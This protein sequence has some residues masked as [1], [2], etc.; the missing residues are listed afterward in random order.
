[1]LNSGTFIQN[2]Y[3]I[4]SKIGSG[5]MADVY[6]AKDH[7]LNRLV[8]IKVLKPEFRDD[9]VFIS[10]FRTEAQSAAGLSHGN[11]VNIYDV[12]EEAGINYIVME[13]VE[14]IT[15]KEYIKDQGRLSVKE[16][17]SIAL[18]IS[19]GLEAAHNNGVIHRDVKPQNIMI[20]TDGKVKV[21]DFG[22]ARAASVNTVTSNV[23]GSVHYSSPEQ[24]R[25]GFSDEK[26]DIY[27]LGITMYEMLTGHVP[28]NGDTA[29]AVAL[30]HL[31]DEMHGPKEEVPEIPYSTNQI[32]LKCTQKKPERRYQNMAELIRDL[33]ESLVNPDGDF[34]SLPLDTDSPTIVMS[35]EDM[36]QLK[37]E[38]KMPSYDESIDV[39][40]AADIHKEDEPEEG[41][42][43]A[44]QTGSYYQQS[45][46]QASGRQD[47]VSDQWDA[48][49]GIDDLDDM[50]D[51]EYHPY[52]D[53]GYE[54]PDEYALRKD[55]DEDSYHLE[56]DF[57]SGGGRNDDDDLDGDLNPN[58]ERAVTIGGIIIAV[59]IGC[60]FLVLLANAFGLFRISGGGNSDSDSNIVII[61]TETEEQTS[62]EETETASEQTTEPVSESETEPPTET[63]D[64]FDLDD[65]SNMAQSEAEE[66]LTSRGL[67]YKIDTSQFSETVPDGDV[68]STDPEAGTEVNRG[69]TVTL[70]ISQG[71]ESDAS[72][73]SL[74]SL[75]GYT[76]DR[77]EEALEMLG[78]SVDYEYEPSDSVTEGYVIG[79]S[80]D[81]NGGEARTGSTVTLYIST[82][83]SDGTSDQSGDH[84]SSTGT[85]AGEEEDSSVKVIDN[86]EIPSNSSSSSASETEGSWQC[87]A[88]LT[89]PAGYTGQE[90]RI[91]LEQNGSE[92]TVFEGTADFPYLLQ[93]S[94]EDDVTTGTAYVYLLD[95]NGD[96]TGKIEYSGIDFSQVE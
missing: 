41:K 85:G 26:S 33:R 19:A 38:Q 61:E 42:N 48:G 32:V 57:D 17:T 77:A 36:D 82:G 80:A 35:K 43:R 44:Y 40:A 73:V 96:V 49:Y 13:L 64:V 52:Y 60:I 9:K 37:S 16:A 67:E 5:G 11:I 18:Q 65:L 94:G 20:S 53:E 3:E 78:L 75:T 84:T 83:P 45:Q 2:R 72:Y 89:A 88:S 15:L 1:M 14:G 86:S 6:K 81:D 56:D 22:I 70:F 66:L 68:I 25:G 46:Y 8:A 79:S 29:V 51:P 74:W 95:D 47:D 55:D 7:K 12:G 90:V 34:V 91:T 58:L 21:A 23:M 30:Q 62:E 31:Q 28:F 54:D 27:S 76:V 50:D 93:V 71:S 39:G 59:V 4:I 69:D 10:K 24:A 87:D 63:P 92:K